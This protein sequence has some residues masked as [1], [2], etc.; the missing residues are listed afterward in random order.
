MKTFLFFFGLLIIVILL[1]FTFYD[2]LSFHFLQ[3]FEESPSKAFHSSSS[4]PHFLTDEDDKK[5]KKITKESFEKDLQD[6]SAFMNT[7][8]LPPSSSCF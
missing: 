7:E 6:I 3:S 1:S 4:D 5:I 8:I 2:S